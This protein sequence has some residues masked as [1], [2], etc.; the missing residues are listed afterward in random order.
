MLEWVLVDKTIEVLF[1]FAG[2]F[3]WAAGAGAIRQPRDAFLVKTMD[4]LAQCGI[5]KVE[6]V[7]DGLK[8]V[9]FDDVAPSLGTPEHPGLLGLFQER[10]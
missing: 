5:G 3:G 4:L 6:R 8:A 9:S 7:R 10:V 1:Q 2:N